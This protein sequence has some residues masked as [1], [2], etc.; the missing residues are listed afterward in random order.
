[1][2]DEWR[3]DMAETTLDKKFDDWA[4]GLAKA[5]EDP[6]WAFWDC[7][8]QV[9][10][11]EYN[12]YL[13]DTPGYVTLDWQLI[14]S[15]LWTETGAN[16]PQWKTKPLQIGVPGD[17]GLSSLLGGKEGGE[18]ILLPQWQARLTANAVKT[19]PEYN[20]RAGIGYLLMRLS[21]SEYRT[22]VAEGSTIGKVTVK[23]GDSL[24]RIARAQGSTT[25]LM[26][27]LNPSATVLRAG[28]VLQVQKAS[29][30]R[31]ITGWKAIS[32]DNIADLYNGGGDSNYAKKLN[33][34]LSLVKKGKVAVC[35]P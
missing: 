32:T 6:K 12:K 35:A 8:T 2:H 27:Q 3:N 9:A 26:K 19:I 11:G 13:G 14:K 4:A 31:V 16:S 15:M 22:V 24:D 1:V 18:L 10:V 23:A 21:N 7:E 33:Y 25:D 5:V 34:A 29:V 30:Q 28:Q 17:P 20:L